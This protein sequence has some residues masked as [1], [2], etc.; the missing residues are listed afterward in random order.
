[1]PARDPIAAIAGFARRSDVDRPD[2]RRRGGFTLIELLIV[3]ALVLVLAWFAVP[4]FTG[5][6][7][8]RRL[9]DSIDQMQSI[10]ALT[11]AHAMNDGRRYRIR[12]PDEEAYEA[13]E[14]NETTLQPIIEVEKDP[15]NEPGEFSE[16]KELWAIGDTLYPGI[17][18]TEVRLGRPKTP[19]QEAQEQE[20]L[21]QIADGVSQM[22]E[23]DEDE[24]EDMF[25]ETPEDALSEEEKDPIRPAIVFE[26]DGTAEWATIFLTNGEENEDEELRTWEIVIDGRT[27]KVAWRRTPTEQEIEDAIAE[28]EE[29][30]EEHKIVRGREAGAM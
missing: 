18:C 3:I 13:A 30:E 4:V 7:Q 27:G 15:I 8:R 21:D 29:E 6:L 1:M 2:A 23:D 28:R 14:E 22:F 5:E 25:D 19:E 20:R 24:L 12:W 16:V 26:P 11:R 9:K 17:Q 10:I